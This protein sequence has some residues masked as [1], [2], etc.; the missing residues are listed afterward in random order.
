MDLPLVM[1]ALMNRWGEDIL[2]EEVAYVMEDKASGST[3]NGAFAAAAAGCCGFPCWQAW[4]DLQDLRE[5]IHDGCSVAVRVERRVMGQ[6][7]PVGVW[8]GLHGFGHDD[9]VLADFVLLND[10]T[11][12]NDGAVNCHMAVSD[13]ARYFTGRAIALRPKPRNTEAD[14]PRRFSCDLNYSGEDDC[15]Y[16]SLRGRRYLLPA[17]FSGWAACSPHDGI[18]HATT[19]HRTFRRMERT[20]TGGLR[21]PPEQVAAGGKC[22]LYL[23]DQTGSM[24]VG[25]V[26]LPVPA[27]PPPP[28]LPQTVPTA[29][30]STEPSA[31]EGQEPRALMDKLSI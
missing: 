31:P 14:R 5:Q 18:A 21:F 12:D 19:A 15:W 17:E 4:M 27:P 11:A 25:Q 28:V 24:L 6:R 30:Q 10:P 8:M 29:S 23:V 9:A 22:S 13:F 1:A 16:I 20:R 3:G 26:I 2:P 7:D